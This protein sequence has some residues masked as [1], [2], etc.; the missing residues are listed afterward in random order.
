MRRTLPLITLVAVAAACAAL[1][2]YRGDLRDAYNRW[3]RGPVPPA[4]T[5]DEALKQS[6]AAPA[7]PA[8]PPVNAAPQ[9]AAE[10]RPDTDGSPEVA[11]PA[12]ARPAS[13]NLKVLFIPQA[14]FKVWDA[15]HEDTCEE[16]SMLMLKTYVDGTDA[17][18]LDDM[19]R[20]L[21]DIITYEQDK[22]GDFR[23]TDAERTAEVMRD[24]LGLRGAEAVTIASLDDVKRE[25]AAGRPVMLPAAGKL[26]KNPNFK[27]GGPLYH[28][29]LA[30][31][32]T[33]SR[34]ITNDPGTRLGADYAYDDDVL[35]NAIHDWNGGDVEHG[36]K[37]MIVVR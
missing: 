35:W 27:N 12:A 18:T 4:I 7:A 1:F 25:I 8:L 31:G 16:A 2:A 24:H 6:A 20:K 15:T 3:R 22:Y 34:I 29:L 32:Y 33:S 23:S 10:P 26:L 9:T 11:A 5:R 17:M 37:V 21:Q 14:P 28:M 30:K 13:Y 19:E 36:A